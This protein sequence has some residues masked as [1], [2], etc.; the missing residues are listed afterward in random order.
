M[1]KPAS[2]LLKQKTY[3]IW[4]VNKYQKFVN[5]SGRFFQLV[6]SIVIA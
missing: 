5:Y 4:I 6:K 1:L 3:D 2:K